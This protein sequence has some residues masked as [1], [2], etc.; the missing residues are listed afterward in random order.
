MSFA[1]NPNHT[2]SQLDLMWSNYTVPLKEESPPVT[3]KEQAENVIKVYG[4]NTV[5]S[6]F[7]IEVLKKIKESTL[8]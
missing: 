8:G 7:A 4:S 3:L 6:D 5:A 2:K 1:N